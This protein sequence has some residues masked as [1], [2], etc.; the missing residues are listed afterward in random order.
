MPVKVVPPVLVNQKS[1]VSKQHI[2]PI[3]V[4]SGFMTKKSRTLNRWKQRWWQLLDNGY[5]F[6]F[7]SDDRL[8]VLGQVDIAR[9]C[10]DVRL[11]AT[12]CR[13]S[14]PR[15]APSCCV[16]SFAVLKRTYHVYTPTAGEAERWAKSISDM[17]RVINRKIY[18]GVERRRAP[19]PPGPSRPPS[20]PPD[21]QIK[22][23]RVKTYNDRGI[24]DSCNDFTRIEY[25]KKKKNHLGGG[26]NLSSQ[27]AMSTSVPDYLDRIGDDSISLANEEEG[28]LDSRLWL[29]GSPPAPAALNTPLQV[30]PCTSPS[31][32]DVEMDAS[33]ESP[34]HSQEPH[35]ADDET[36]PT[37]VTRREYFTTTPTR[38]EHYF[39][40]PTAVLELDC[41]DD[42]QDE[43]EEVVLEEP[44]TSGTDVLPVLLA[45]ELS[46][47]DDAAYTQTRPVPLPRK[48]K[49][50]VHPLET[51]SKGTTDPVAAAAEAG[52]Y[53]CLSLQHSLLLSSMRPRN[54]SEPPQIRPRKGSGSNLKKPNR[55]RKG[56]GVRLRKISPPST[57]PPPP[58]SICSPIYDKPSIKKDSGPPSFIPPPPPSPSLISP[59]N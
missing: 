10:Y 32:G 17:S 27:K 12:E 52:D 47:D 34:V 9:S 20:C 25:V 53:S 4:M 55:P 58:P 36:D 5:L 31:A 30:H 23:T 42:T 45:G 14:F 37:P 26:T 54:N 29:D 16:I 46:Q 41:A 59:Y 19:D 50:L 40:L 3:T 38:K 28:S 49:A 6:Y 15:A 51:D 33:W 2:G 21:Y 57:P 43:D 44:S 39:S 8:K 11:G 56:S 18:A 13:V 35:P 48:G 24:S 1:L 22:M 7:K